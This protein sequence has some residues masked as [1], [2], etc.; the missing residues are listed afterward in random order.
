MELSDHA[1]DR[2]KRRKVS[3]EE[4]RETLENPE[5]VLFD[6][7]TGYFIAIRRR[8][9]KWLIVVYIPT[10][11]TRVISVIVTSKFNIVEKRVKQGVDKGMKVRY[12][13]DSDILYISIKDEDVEDMDELGEDIFVEYNKNGEIIG[14]EI[15]QARKY[16]IPEILKFIKAAK[17]VG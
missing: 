1:I 12:D 3:E 6:T 11:R 15:W 7:Q 13:A 16:V 5:E 4:I 9:R 17:E 8:N 14:I 10:E 2:M